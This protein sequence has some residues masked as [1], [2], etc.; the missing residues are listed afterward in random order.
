MTI[1]IFT[2][3]EREGAKFRFIISPF[4][5]SIPEQIKKKGLW[6]V[7]EKVSELFQRK[8]TILYAAEIRNVVFS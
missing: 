3:H 4:A 2:R 7:K 6:E 1:I 8:E 5:F